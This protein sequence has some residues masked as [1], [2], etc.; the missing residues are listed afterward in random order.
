MNEQNNFGMRRFGLFPPVL[1]TLMIIN[2]VVFVVQHFML[3]NFTAAGVPLD[4]LIVHYFALQPL[5]DG[6]SYIAINSFYPWQVI[7][8]QFMHAG[9]WHIFFNLFVLWM[10]G[11]ELEEIWG[12]GKFITFYIL[13]GIGAAIAQL[14]ISPMLGTIAPTVGASGSVYGILL[15]FGLTFPDRPIYMFPFF[16][17]IKAKIF[18]GIMMLIELFFGL[19]GSDGIARFAHLGGAATGFLLLKFGDS[20]KLFTF[21]QKLLKDKPKS[22]NTDYFHGSSFGSVR[23]EPRIHKFTWQSTKT[24]TPVY[25]TPETSASKIAL[26]LNGEEITQAKIDLILD[27]I[28]ANGYQSLTEKEKYILTELSKRL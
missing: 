1:K 8:Y 3:A 9:F 14:I 18:V 2:L 24:E 19:S 5:F 20:L 11:S 27:K 7:S 15:A 25:S 12:R 23:Q 16:I 21:A 4:R 13:S 17:P 22:P 10:F 6:E 26:T 28:S